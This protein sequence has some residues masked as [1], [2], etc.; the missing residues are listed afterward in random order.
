MYV[1]V[2]YVKVAQAAVLL[3]VAKLREAVETV[4][5]GRQPGG[6]A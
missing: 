3:S 4:A 1:C 6:G 2:V 5:S